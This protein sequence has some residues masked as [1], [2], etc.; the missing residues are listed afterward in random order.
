M[1]FS[2]LF[3]A[4]RTAKV[5][6]VATGTVVGT[7]TYAKTP[8][9]KWKI[10]PEQQARLERLR[11]SNFEHFFITCPL[12]E[13]NTFVVGPALDA[14][15]QRHEDLDA[16]FPFTKPQHAHVIALATQAGT[17]GFIAKLVQ[18][19]PTKRSAA[20]MDAYIEAHAPIA[21][22]IEQQ[23]EDCKRVRNLWWIYKHHACDEIVTF[24]NPSDRNGMGVAIRIAEQD[25]AY[26]AEFPGAAAKRKEIKRLGEEAEKC[27]EEMIKAW[28][29]KEN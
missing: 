21:A 11:E 6:S 19:A 16:H 4:S 1:M 7:K 24:A 28:E 29:S 27:V 5:L 8:E 9:V 10:T 20:D 26:E 15:I 14:H 25:A 13:N 22:E 2:R 12:D 23:W 17:P 18:N 3:R